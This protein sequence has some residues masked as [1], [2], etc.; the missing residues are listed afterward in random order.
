M[1]D[2][3]AGDSSMNRSKGSAND[4]SSTVGYNSLNKSTGIDSQGPSLSSLTMRFMPL[5]EC[6][7]TVSRYTILSPLPASSD[8]ESSKNPL[9]RNRD[10]CIDTIESP[11]AETEQSSEQ[12]PTAIDISTSTATAETPL[13]L[14]TARSVSAIGVALQSATKK[15]GLPGYGF[16]QHAAYMRMQRELCNGEASDRFKTFIEKNDILLNMI[17]RQNVHLLESSFSTLILAPFCRHRLH[18]DIK[19][20]YFKGKL[21][22][23]KQNSSRMQGSLRIQVNRGRVLDDSFRKLRHCKAEEMRKRVSIS[24]TGEE[25]MDAGGLTREWY[26][27]L[28]REIFDERVPLFTSMGSNV[29]FQPS[30]LSSLSC[31]D[32]DHLDYFK[33]VGRIIGKALCDGQLLDA[34][35]TR[36]F[37]KHILGLPITYRDL[38]AIEP[39]YY[40]SLLQILEFSLD[41][42]GVDMTFS[43]DFNELGQVTTV[44]LI[45]NGRNI[46]V[47]DENKMLSV[48]LIAHHRTTTAIREQID[49]FLAGF[50]ELV[51]PE[52]ISIFDAQE[53]ELLISGLPEI[54]LNDLRAHTDYCGYKS[55]DIQI[56]W[57]WNCL[58][59]FSK[60]EKALFLQFVTGTSKVPLEGFANLTG[61]DGPRRFNIQKAFGSHL[62]PSAHTCFNQLDLP[63]YSSEEEMKEKLLTA[64]R[65]GSEGFGFA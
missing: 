38:E 11:S 1:G 53:L 40:K 46:P 52:L 63:E 25:G 44:D 20:A 30:A 47:T 41:D 4:L 42:I 50:H 61:S 21:K 39:D 55:S 48:Q 12:L 60:E 9:K 28:A 51:P 17:L 8:Y 49:A 56:T 14:S 58:R 18:F 33:F 34:H 62:L 15:E 16:R 23:M 22:K 19:R 64:I 35:F 3:A 57:F 6:Y 43:A 36:T 7:L 54:D 31:P 29:T 65:E 26:T 13:R 59:A 2:I 5:I 10:E 24:F 45:E 37:Y 32:E 27:V